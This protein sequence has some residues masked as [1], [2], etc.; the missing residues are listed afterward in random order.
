MDSKQIAKGETMQVREHAMQELGAMRKQLRILVITTILSY[1]VAGVIVVL[2]WGT[3]D[4]LRQGVCS[5]RA[6]LEDRVENSKQF[7]HDR[8]D[9]IRALGFTPP[10]VRE[11][12][13]NQERTIQ[14]LSSIQC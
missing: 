1:I 3:A 4:M 13:V 6:D 11:Q 14:A 5:L 10:E 12:I 7:L 9:A 8:P 2:A